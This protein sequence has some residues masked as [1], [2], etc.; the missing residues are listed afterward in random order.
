[1]VNHPPL[2]LL[3]SVVVQVFRF[4]I[5][6][7]G[8]IARTV[9][10]DEAK[11]VTFTYRLPFSCRSID[12]TNV[13][14]KDNTIDTTASAAIHPNAIDT[15]DASAATDTSDAS[16][17]IHHGWKPVTGRSSVIKATGLPASSTTAASK[18]TVQ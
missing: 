13:V 14:Y 2:R 12:E 10:I 6:A 7:T 11:T 5:R 1:M 3:Q 4:L 16:A 15:S 17:A 9:S 8:Y 18:A